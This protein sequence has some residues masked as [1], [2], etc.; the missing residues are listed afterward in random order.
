M[1]TNSPGVHLAARKP[2]LGMWLAIAAMGAILAGLVY[3]GLTS[4]DTSSLGPAAVINPVRP[5][6]KLPGQSLTGPQRSEISATVD[7][8]VPATNQVP[9][10]ERAQPG[11][12]SAYMTPEEEKAYYGEG[13]DQAAG[14]GRQ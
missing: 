3:L 9:N 2:L 11:D 14:S 1:N 13:Q 8:P 5:P 6:F 4:Q 7:A 10:E 12:D